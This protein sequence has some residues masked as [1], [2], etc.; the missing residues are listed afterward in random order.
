YSSTTSSWSYSELVWTFITKYMMN[1]MNTANAHTIHTPQLI[2]FMVYFLQRDAEIS[3]YHLIFITCWSIERPRSEEIHIGR[4][5]E[6]VIGIKS[7]FQFGL[8]SFQIFTMNL[9]K[10]RSLRHA[11]LFQGNLRFSD[12]NDRTFV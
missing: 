9:D 4:F 10:E 7:D 1:E 8:V 5:D 12:R 11:F 3:V 6:F 2:F